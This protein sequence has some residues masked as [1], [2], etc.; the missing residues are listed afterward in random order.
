LEDSILKLAW[1]GKEDKSVG[2]QYEFD[3]KTGEYK[4][5]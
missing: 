3:L 2:P 5:G 4:R 1:D